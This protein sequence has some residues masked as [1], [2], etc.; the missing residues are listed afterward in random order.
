[1]STVTYFIAVLLSVLMHGLLIFLLS[2]GWQHRPTELAIRPPMEIVQAS[3]VELEAKAPPK[4]APQPEVVDL[5]AQRQQEAEELARVEAEKKR[6]ETEKA[7]EKKAQEEAE[8]KKRLEEEREREEL[9]A[10]K[11]REEEERLAQ[12]EAERRRVEEFNEALAAEEGYQAN[13]ASEQVVASASSLIQ[14]KVSQNWNSPPS[15]RRGMVATVRVNMVPTGRVVNVDIAE[16]SGNAAFDL[17][18][19][20]AVQKAQPFESVR[21]LDPAVFERNFRE[22]SFRFDPQ[23]LRL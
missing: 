9:D 2:F 6:I 8:Q 11:K 7:A 17:A 18:V 5:S 12:E 21:E 4:A 3:L 20:Q 19:V 16:S 13:I 14:Q 10:Q 15:A 1:M 22:F 23:N